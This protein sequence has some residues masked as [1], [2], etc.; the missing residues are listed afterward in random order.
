MLT[1]GKEAVFERS[2]KITTTEDSTR[3]LEMISQQN[4]AII[5]KYFN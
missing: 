3:S 2:D 1:S 5:G 4:T